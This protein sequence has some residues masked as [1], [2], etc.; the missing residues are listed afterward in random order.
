MWLSLI[1]T[2]MKSLIHEEDE[3]FKEIEVDVW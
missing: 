2:K 1:L 3:S